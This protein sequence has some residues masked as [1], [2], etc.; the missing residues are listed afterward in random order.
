VGT[1]IGRIKQ[2]GRLLCKQNWNEVRRDSEWAGRGDTERSFCESGYSKI[3]KNTL[4][5]KTMMKNGEITN[6][7]IVDVSIKL[8]II[9]IRTAVITMIII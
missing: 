4:R 5:N 9:L 8:M 1:R 7:N 2:H 6:T 3:F